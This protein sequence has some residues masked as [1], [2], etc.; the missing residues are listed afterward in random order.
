[1]LVNILIILSSIVSAFILGRWS[2]SQSGD[3]KNHSEVLEVATTVTTSDEPI[4][5]KAIFR[6][7]LRQMETTIL[8]SDYM[9]WNYSG[10]DKVDV[11]IKLIK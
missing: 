3:A 5:N 10:V 11:K 2:K 4:S 9:N 8:N 1:M 7:A 6:K